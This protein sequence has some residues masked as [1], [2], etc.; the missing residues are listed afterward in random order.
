MVAHEKINF[1][2]HEFKASSRAMMISVPQHYEFSGNRAGLDH[3]VCK[4]CA[5]FSGQLIP[6]LCYV[7]PSLRRT[8]QLGYSA[9]FRRH[10][11]TAPVFC[12]LQGERAVVATLNSFLP[13]SFL[14]SILQPLL[15]LDFLLV[16][17]FEQTKRLAHNLPG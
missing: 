1:V 11:A 16:A 12:R 13:D 9:G 6:N 4:G 10:P 17:A 5:P 3:V 7:G 14:P 2:R 8:D 15:L